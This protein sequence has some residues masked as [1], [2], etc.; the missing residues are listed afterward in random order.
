MYLLS[1]TQ[2]YLR[3]LSESHQKGGKQNQVLSLWTS[4][5]IWKCLRHFALIKVILKYRLHPGVPRLTKQSGPV[6]CQ[7]VGICGE[8]IFSSLNT[9]KASTANKPTPMLI[10]E[11]QQHILIMNTGETNLTSALLLGQG[12]PR[13][14]E[15]KAQSLRT[16]LGDVTMVDGLPN[17][18]AQTGKC[19]KKR[20]RDNQPKPLISKPHCRLSPRPHTD[21]HRHIHSL[22]FHT[23]PH[24]RGYPDILGLERYFFLIACFI[25]RKL[26]R[27]VGSNTQTSHV[28]FT[29]FPPKKTSAQTTAQYHNQDIGTADTE[30]RH[31]VSSLLLPSHSHIQPLPNPWQPLICLPFL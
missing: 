23:F 16:I 2:D 9:S 12:Y 4:Q 22:Q 11:Q 20:K 14:P 17:E 5:H 13:T 27:A 3:P 31:P 8:V 19:Q 15:I 28:C 29:R 1:V 21:R 7:H 6:P 24:S 30:H 10:C 25:L 18:M 26:Y